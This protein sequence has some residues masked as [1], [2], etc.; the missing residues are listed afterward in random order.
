MNSHDSPWWILL[1]KK[2][3]Q[4]N[5]ETLKKN[6][7][8]KTVNFDKDKGLWKS[9][10]YQQSRKN[11]KFHKRGDPPYRRLVKGW[12]IFLEFLMITYWVK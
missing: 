5:M 8:N 4:K 3:S 12:V 2:K 6:H 10:F 7:E 11:S 9:T 1:K